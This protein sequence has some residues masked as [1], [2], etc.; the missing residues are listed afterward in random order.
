MPSGVCTTSGWNCTAWIPRAGSS[1]AA[2]G[3]DRAT[4][5]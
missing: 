2:I 3:D 1:I 4:T 5:P